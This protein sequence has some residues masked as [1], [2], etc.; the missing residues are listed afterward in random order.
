MEHEITADW[1]TLMGQ[2]HSTAYTYLTEAKKDID[3]V[4][5]TGYAMKNPHLVAAYMATAA[6]DFQSSSIGVAAQKIRDALWDL[7]ESRTRE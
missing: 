7:G 2:A 1:Q 3:R 4:F 5:G 6:Q